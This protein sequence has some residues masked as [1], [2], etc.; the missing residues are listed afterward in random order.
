MSHPIITGILSYGMSGR[1]FHAPFVDISP[2]FDLYAVTE[3]ST[4]KANERYRQVISY[5]SVDELLRDPKVE[6]VIVN[7]PN[8]THF[9]FAKKALEAG[10]HILVEKPFASSSEEAKQ[11]FDLGRQK[12]CKV[13]VYQNRRFDSDFQNVKSVIKSG[14]LG[15]L[16]EVNFRFDR[17]RREISQKTFKEQPLPASGL[18]Y[19]LGPHLIDQVISLFGKPL[20]VK[21]TSGIFRPDSQV[22]DYIHY[23][24][25]FPENL[26][27]FVTSS[28]LVAHPLPAFVVHGT[29]GSFIKSRSDGQETQLDQGL[30]PNDPDY[31]V[32]PDGS[33]GHLTIIDKGGNKKTEY[34][35][36]LRAN[37]NHLFNAV[38]STVR[39]NE[40]F[41]VKEEEIIWQMEILENEEYPSNP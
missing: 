30:S 11:L 14:K 16:I 38:Y 41:P 22:D 32:E 35:T 24:L 23:H 1:V 29:E 13:M 20:A 27:V 19:D 4:K 25:I 21:G 28:L 15:R 3:R 17:Y 5:N 6:L 7:T 9:E 34:I 10:K 36:S 39:N 37:Y 26:N 40:P 33:E 18:K 12:E 8:N 31:G 2:L